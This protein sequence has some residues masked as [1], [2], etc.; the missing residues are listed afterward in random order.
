[1][2]YVN[3][4]IRVI[5]NIYANDNYF[6]ASSDACVRQTSRI[7]CDAGAPGI[8]SL[9]MLTYV[10]TLLASA[11]RTMHAFL[12]ALSVMDLYFLT[13][14]LRPTSVTIGEGGMV[15]SSLSA[16]GRKY[17]ERKNKLLFSS[18]IR[19]SC[20][21]RDSPG[22]TALARRCLSYILPTRGLHSDK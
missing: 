13:H 20:L 3:Q 17:D 14:R 9:T 6:F 1:M 16:D 22:R 21:V 4:T 18:T 11:V 19:S 7:S 15:V 2:Y 12:R 5:I 10:S 8:M